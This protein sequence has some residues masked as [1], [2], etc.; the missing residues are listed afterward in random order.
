MQEFWSIKRIIYD[1]FRL[2]HMEIFSLHTR[3]LFQ[4]QILSPIVSG[5]LIVIEIAAVLTEEYI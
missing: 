5:C 4:K 3:T 2:L 1:L